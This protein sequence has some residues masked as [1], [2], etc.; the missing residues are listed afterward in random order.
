MVPGMVVTAPLVRRQHDAWTPPGQEVGRVLPAHTHTNTT[1][2]TPTC[3]H[4]QQ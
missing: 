4:T 1:T 2:T 3:H